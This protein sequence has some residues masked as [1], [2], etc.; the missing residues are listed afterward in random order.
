M[1]NSRCSKC[2]SDKILEVEG[3]IGGY[4][5]GSNIPVGWL[6]IR[7]VR[8]TRYLCEACG[9]IESWVL[10]PE[11]RAKVAKRYGRRAARAKN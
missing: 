2:Q 6:A 8:V 3:N 1:K 11:D 7:A 4:G 10:S 5:A 9:F